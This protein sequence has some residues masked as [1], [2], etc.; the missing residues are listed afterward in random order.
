M[1]A[2]ARRCEIR[3]TFLAELCNKILLLNFILIVSHGIY[4]KTHQKYS[5]G[6]HNNIIDH[7]IEIYSNSCLFS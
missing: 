3:Y 5:E 4:F 2:V 6:I 7:V 1:V